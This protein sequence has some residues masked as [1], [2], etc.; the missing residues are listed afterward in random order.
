V[1]FSYSADQKIQALLTSKPFFARHPRPHSKIA[2]RA[3]TPGVPLHHTMPPPASAYR[4]NRELAGTIYV[5]ED[6]PGLIESLLEKLERI[7][8]L[9]NVLRVRSLAG[10]AIGCFAQALAFQL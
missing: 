1:E 6:K 4:A 7:E 2:C 10:Y 9:L 3:P 5:V 8:K